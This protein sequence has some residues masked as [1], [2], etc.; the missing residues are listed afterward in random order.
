[1]TN[2]INNTNSGKVNENKASRASM[3]DG[4]VIPLAF[5]SGNA[6]PAVRPRVSNTEVSVDYTPFEEED[7]NV[8]AEGVFTVNEPVTCTSSARQS[9][10]STI[11]VAS[12][13]KATTKRISVKRKKKTAVRTKQAKKRSREV[14]ESLA[15]ALSALI[16]QEG[17]NKRSKRSR[18]SVVSTEESNS[19]DS[20]SS[21]DSSSEE[22]HISTSESESDFEV[23]KPIKK[24][25]KTSAAVKE[26]L[27]W[28]AVKVATRYLRSSFQ[29][30]S[31]FC[32]DDP[33][34]RVNAEHYRDFKRRITNVQKHGIFPP[35]CF[36]SALTMCIN[37]FLGGYVAKTVSYAIDR[38][39]P[40]TQVLEILDVQ[41]LGRYT[42]RD[43]LLDALSGD[44]VTDR[45]TSLFASSA[46]CDQWLEIIDIT[47]NMSKDEFLIE[48]MKSQCSG[49]DTLQHIATLPK[50]ITPLD[51]I[52][53]MTEFSTKRLKSLINTGRGTPAVQTSAVV[54]SSRKRGHRKRNKFLKFSSGHGEAFR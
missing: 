3:V 47:A 10:A 36:E 7:K 43:R 6:A 30:V 52:R 54:T 40:M 13:M 17:R 12:S 1:M 9:V 26:S 19:D 37:D 24:K 34:P 4:V 29:N 8:T 22:S 20:E 14:L 42:L 31:R 18:K 45:N 35:D 23:E 27:D 38:N 16:K 50:T 5:D 32:G 28:E 11:I 15:S 39:K 25:T 51:F 48:L 49:R 44:F 2:Q 21:E 46:K 53:S 33:N 41:F